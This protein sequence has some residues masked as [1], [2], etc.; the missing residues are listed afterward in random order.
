MRHLRIKNWDAFQNYDHKKAN[1]WIR[2]YNW[3]LVD[4]AFRKLTDGAKLT[5]HNI[6]L[7][8]STVILDDDS[9]DPW[10]PEPWLNAHDLGMHGKPRV[11]EVVAAG[12]ASWTLEAPSRAIRRREPRRP[13]KFSRVVPSMTLKSSSLSSFSPEEEREEKP[14][15]IAYLRQAISVLIPKT[16]ATDHELAQW[17]A[18]C[19]GDEARAAAIIAAKRDYV[20]GKRAP[21]VAEVLRD[22]RNEE[23]TDPR[24]YVAFSVRSAQRRPA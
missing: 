4:D 12:F 2:L 11:G 7:L 3:L 13:T 18:L 5:L 14:L 6:W 23:I 9:T 8:G 24:G 15:Q 22:Q 16:T 1:A 19:D 21:Y 20:N 17:I 10:I